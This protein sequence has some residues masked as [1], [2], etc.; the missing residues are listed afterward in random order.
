M[1]WTKTRGDVISDSG[2]RF[3][4]TGTTPEAAV[5]LLKMQTSTYF[6]EGGFLVLESLRIELE[7]PHE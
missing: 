3:E 7:G 2:G 6:A 4:L 1:I 5:A